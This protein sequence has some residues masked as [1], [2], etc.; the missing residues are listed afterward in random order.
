MSAHARTR[1]E[2]ILEDRPGDFEICG[3]EAHAAVDELHD[4]LRP[5][6]G[7]GE[8]HPSVL[9]EQAAADLARLHAHLAVA[10]VVA[11]QRLADQVDL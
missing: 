2:V 6:R 4:R 10:S 7:Q 5:G 11:Q 1:G 8:P 9:D 3:P